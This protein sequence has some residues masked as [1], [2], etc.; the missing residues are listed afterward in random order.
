[1]KKLSH[2]IPSLILICILLVTLPAK[3]VR[4]DE[5]EEI[6][7]QAWK[8]FWSYGDMFSEIGIYVVAWMELLVILFL[9]LGIWSNKLKF[10]GWALAFLVLMWALFSH[11]FTP[12]GINVGW[13]RGLL[14]FLALI[15]TVASIRILKK[16]YKIFI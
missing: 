5:L 6:F 8:A 10:Y 16:T 2:H 11:L 4:W 3:L 12:L 15:G 9:F 7:M 13:D 14:F 1:M